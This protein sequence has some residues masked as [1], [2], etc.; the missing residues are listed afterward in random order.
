M[1]LATAVVST[2]P[3]FGISQVELTIPQISVQPHQRNTWDGWLDVVHSAHNA[4]NFADIPGVVAAFVTLSNL[5]APASSICSRPLCSVNAVAAAIK[6]IAHQVTNNKCSNNS[7]Q[8]CVMA[9]MVACRGVCQEVRAR[10]DAVQPEGSSMRDV[11]DIVG[12][13]WAYQKAHQ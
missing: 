13:L 10:D 2:V 7:A 9:T 1:L 11:A 8:L 12:W 5:S 3:L 4:G 6:P